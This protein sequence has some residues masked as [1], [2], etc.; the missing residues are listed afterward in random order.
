MVDVCD[1][2]AAGAQPQPARLACAGP[3]R[4]W[5]AHEGNPVKTDSRSA[6]PGGTPFVV[7]GVLYR[8]SQDC[9]LSYGRQITIN[10]VEELTEGT[11][12]E[13]PVRLLSPDRRSRYP[14]GFHTMA[15][16]GARTLVD[17]NAR[18]LVGATLRLTARRRIAPI[19]GWLRPPG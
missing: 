6:R 10:A 9:E 12:I 11:F 14:A 17:G 19:T 15:Q 18:G 4:T 1:E 2:R 3:G 13:R 7:D 5:T 16:V 8:P